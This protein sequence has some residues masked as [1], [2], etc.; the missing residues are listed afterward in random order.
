M[1]I[2]EGSAIERSLEPT[3]VRLIIVEDEPDKVDALTN[4]LSVESVPSN[5]V[6]EVYGSLAGFAG[7][8]RSGDV[9]SRTTDAVFLDG[10]LG[11]SRVIGGFE[12]YRTMSEH[13]LVREGMIPGEEI[14][15]GL[16]VTVGISRDLDI[17]RRLATQTD[18]GPL[19]VN[20][21]EEPLQLA[22]IVSEI[23]R[24]KPL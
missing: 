8:V 20:W 4:A 16:L 21:E 14:N 23:R 15:P 9:S 12:A 22:H 17:A 24:L 5:S 7:A 11:A 3:P 19:V 6:L 10:H 2:P 1:L 13:Y 18:A